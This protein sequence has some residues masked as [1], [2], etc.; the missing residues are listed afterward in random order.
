M[1]DA[2]AGPDAG[3]PYVVA[4][5]ERP[6]IEETRRDPRRL[7]IAFDVRSPI[8]APVHPEHVK[9]VLRAAILLGKLGHDV[10][11]ARPELDLKALADSY[12]TVLCGEVAAEFEE[13]EVHLGRRLR[14]GD[15]EAAT[16]IIGM[17]GR[18]LPA[19]PF[20][21]ARRLWGSASR[22][23]GR[24]HRTYDL[25]L[26]PTTAQPP[27]RIGEL[28]PGPLEMAGMKTAGYLRLGLV[29]RKSGIFANSVQR[30]LARTPFTQLANLTGQPAM[31][32]PLH[33][34]DQG[35]PCGVHFTAPIGDEATLFQLAAQLE[36]EAPW[37]NRR[38]ALA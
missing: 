3:A 15:V 7:R 22:A 26:T 25:Y 12:V 38:A 14:P 35:L 30:N 21:C 18:S 10:E 13:V 32:V 31:S 23:M 8:D 4:P 19:V 17:V 11:E 28:L 1:L 5:P 6:F 9:A 27:A 37:F 24:F 20:A 29:L 2:V 34:T 36:R 16:W 33:W